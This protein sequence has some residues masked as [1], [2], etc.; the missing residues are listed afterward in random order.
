MKLPR[1]LADLVRPRV[2]P[3]I[4]KWERSAM[5]LRTHRVSPVDLAAMATDSMVS[6]ALSIKRLG[7][8]A[9]PYRI[10]GNDSKRVAFIESAFERMHGSPATVLADVMT[11]FATGW[12]I[13]E[14]V[15]KFDSGQ[16]LIERVE[17]RDSDRFE[18]E[19]DAYGNLSGLRLSDSREVLPH[20]RFAIYRYRSTLHRPRGTSDLEAAHSHFRAK[21][22]LLDAWDKHLAS[23][24]S[25]TMIG[26]VP[27]T[28]SQLEAD[29]AFRALTKLADSAAITLPSEIDI[30]RIGGE[31][32][33]STGF[34]EAI[35]FHNREIARCILGQTLTTDEGRRVG[36]LALGKV[37]MQV[38]LIQL[39][40]L[41][42]E[43][44]DV[45]MTEQI[46]RPLTEMNFGPGEVPR[47]EFEER[48]VELGVVD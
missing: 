11:A 13:L 48:K 10:T 5:E 22:R 34:M 36:S 3:P 37:H 12:S 43:L 31:T 24:A 28:V 27:R 40:A 45:V 8:L 41:R 46:I 21:R 2:T 38:L 15:Y 1:F 14:P 17:L 20:E 35:D 33:A 19:F 42:R 47:F 6:T 4:P 18:P 23:F 25:P 7:V 32:V 16:V 26:R 44:A 9:V 30:D 29:Q 39:S